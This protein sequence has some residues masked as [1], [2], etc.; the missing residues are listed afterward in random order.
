FL[1][2]RR[3]ADQLDDD[4]DVPGARDLVGVGG[5]ARLRADDL[6][7]PARRLVGDPRDPDR[8][9]RA[10]LDLVAVAAENVPDAAADRADAE[11]PDADRAH[12]AAP[13]SSPS[14]LNISRTPR[15]AW[16]RRCSFSISAMRT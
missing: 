10:A 11:Q 1:R 2:D 7:R 6:A 5:D 16:R 14:F 3:T 13:R 12:Q 8:A 4:V 15:V 9:P